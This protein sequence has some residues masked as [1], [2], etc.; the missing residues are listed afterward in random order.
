M[1]VL[2]GRL[3][4]DWPQPLADLLTRRERG[5]LTIEAVASVHEVAVS[6][7]QKQTVRGLLVDPAVLTKRDVESLA[8]ISRR[9]GV[10]MLLLPVS[11]VP[12]EQERAHE[13]ISHGALC[14]E[15]AAVLLSLPDNHAPING[16]IQSPPTPSAR[17]VGLSIFGNA[18]AAKTVTIN[19]STRYDEM[20]SDPLVTDE[21]LQALL[22]T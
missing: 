1:L 14:W 6:L 5:Q 8:L 21:E 2:L 7:V 11:D 20:R 9:M 22:G 10:K 13:A 4:R 15:D 17:A 18:P 19:T 16:N 3:R 12:V